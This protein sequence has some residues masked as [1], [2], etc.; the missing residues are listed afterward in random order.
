MTTTNP[1]PAAWH[2][3]GAGAWL[4]KRGDETI[5]QVFRGHDPSV[6]CSWPW[7]GSARPI[8]LRRNFESAEEGKRYVLE[9]V[10]AAPTAQSEAAVNVL[11]RTIVAQRDAALDALRAANDLLRELP[12]TAQSG[13]ATLS[14]DSLET[15]AEAAEAL[16][17]DADCLRIAAGF[18]LRH[19]EARDHAS[20]GAR[21][22]RAAAEARAILAGTPIP[23]S[24]VIRTLIDSANRAAE[25]IER[26]AT[27]YVSDRG[28]RDEYMARAR[29]LR[30][31]AE[32]AEAGSIER[33]RAAGR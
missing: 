21:L 33:W 6:W 2:L 29:G 18:N 16:A 4:L 15:L 1:L 31:H 13:A 23:Q 5:G 14:R 9:A 12:P 30:V 10:G 24:G 19:D 8:E 26:V 11:C 17:D 32:Q 20:K 3:T 22:F 25:A 27:S 7:E 28:T